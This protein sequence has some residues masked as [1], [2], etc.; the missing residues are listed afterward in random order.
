MSK[1]I[2]ILG[3]GRFASEVMDLLDESGDY[4]VKAFVQNLDSEKKNQSVLDLPII[5]IED[6]IPLVLDHEAVCGFGA[7]ERVI[8]IKQANDLGFRF[9]VV[10]HPSVKIS[11]K[12]SIDVGTILL[13]GSI[14][15]SY[16][17][18]GK[19]VIVNRGCLIGHHVKIK[20]YVTINPGV[21]IAGSVTIG[22][23]TIIGM[24]AVILNHISIGSYCVVG[25]GAV[26][27]K[28]VSDNVQVL[29]VPA[30]ITKVFTEK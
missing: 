25:A 9:P 28:D 13:P 18:V 8:F 6:A 30:K 12:S 7:K 29:G 24:G 1:K 22:E 15:A 21:N 27:T 20:D 14:I 5:W 4:E 2:V 17:E 11:T 23:G 19:Y 16:T 26:V 3:A 10:A